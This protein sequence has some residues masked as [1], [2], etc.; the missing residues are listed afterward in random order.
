MINDANLKPPSDSP[1]SVGFK[2]NT[3]L[4]Y[5]FLQDFITLFFIKLYQYV[6]KKLI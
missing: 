1:L 2:K 3:K 5:I 4:L 6:K